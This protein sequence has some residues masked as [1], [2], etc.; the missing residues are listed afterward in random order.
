MNSE[1][2]KNLNI[3]IVLGLLIGM[4][5]YFVSTFWGS[6]EYISYDLACVTIKNESSFNI[7]KLTLKHKNGS[8]E[9]TNIRDKEQ[10]RFLFNNESENTFFINA[11]LENDT[12]LISDEVYF[13]SAYKGI[14]VITSKKIK[15]IDK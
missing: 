14:A 15:I 10:I 7:K 5:V 8:I 11:N 1:S 9:A 12:N 6:L 4:F 13:E 3:G 2:M